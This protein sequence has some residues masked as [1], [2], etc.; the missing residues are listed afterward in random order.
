MS[1]GGQSQHQESVQFLPSHRYYTV[2]E[3]S[4]KTTPAR[5]DPRSD[6]TNY[7]NNSANRMNEAILAVIL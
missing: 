1:L 3:Q 2:P 6:Y 7:K 5:A 4:L